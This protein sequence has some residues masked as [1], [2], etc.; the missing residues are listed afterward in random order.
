[1]YS[2]DRTQIGCGYTYTQVIYINK[3]QEYVIGWIDSCA[4]KCDAAASRPPP[5]GAAA[6]PM[7]PAIA[8]AVDA[9]VAAVVDD[10]YVSGTVSAPGPASA[11]DAAVEGA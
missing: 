11:E 1:M 6:G 7:M 9:A 5:P 8:D 10:V 4:I 3:N 2:L